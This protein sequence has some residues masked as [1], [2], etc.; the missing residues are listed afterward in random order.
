[1]PAFNPL[2]ALESS[3]GMLRARR[4]AI[5]LMQACLD[6]SME[7]L[8]KSRECIKRSDLLIAQLGYR[9]QVRSEPTQE[10]EMAG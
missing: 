8:R 5:Q 7:S 10:D 9:A 1:M 6:R 3:A 2:A 4:D